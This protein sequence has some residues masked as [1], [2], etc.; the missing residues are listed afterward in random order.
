MTDAISK[1]APASTSGRIAW[2]VEIIAVQ[3][4]M[5]AKA[6]PALSVS[7]SKKR[8]LKN[9]LFGLPACVFPCNFTPS[10]AFANNVDDTPST[11]VITQFATSGF[12]ECCHEYVPRPCPV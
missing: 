4:G 7:C 1:I 8:E 5:E 10:K 6:V 2:L 12:T 11:V 9:S 3:A